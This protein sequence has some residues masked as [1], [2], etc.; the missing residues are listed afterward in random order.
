MSKQTK[1]IVAVLIIL[2]PA[3]IVLAIINREN[4]SERIAL[5]ESGTFLVTAF[6][7]THVVSLDDLIAI[8]VTNISSHPRG[9]ERNFTGVPV[10]TIFEFLGID[11]TQ[12]EGRRALVFTSL[13]GF[14][15]SITLNEA[16]DTSNAFV[17][18]EENGEPLGTRAEGG[19]GP[20]M[21]VMALDSFPNRWARYLMEITLI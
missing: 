17:A 5:Q 4:V 18:F 20:F 11:L 3:V 6:D 2:I 8:G 9:V 13:D 12:A 15:T 10:M 16:M 21:I 14:A 7:Y 1:I 19:L